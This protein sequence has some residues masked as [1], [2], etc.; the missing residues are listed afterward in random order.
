MYQYRSPD[1]L[2]YLRDCTGYFTEQFLDQDRKQINKNRACSYHTL[3]SRLCAYASGSLLIVIFSFTTF[4]LVSFL[5]FGQ[6][7]G[8]FNNTV[9][10]Y[11]FVFVRCIQFRQGIHIDLLNNFRS[12]LAVLP[13]TITNS[14]SHSDI[15][16]ILHTIWQIN[17]A[18]HHSWTT[19]CYLW[20]TSQS[21]KSN[22]IITL[23]SS[24]IWASSYTTNTAFHAKE[25]QCISHDHKGAKIHAAN[26]YA[27]FSMSER[28]VIYNI[29]LTRNLKTN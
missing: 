1:T 3:G 27:L 20:K 16:H 10:S 18:Q 11:T 13:I 4:T 29:F 21:T 9:S 15:L 2:L 26:L 24:V 28:L 17:N 6:N 19:V 7:K 12:S 25:N 8:K 22:A 14:L 5:H 23:F